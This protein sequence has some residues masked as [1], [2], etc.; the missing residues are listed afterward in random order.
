MTR[1]QPPETTAPLE[2][3]CPFCG[4]VVGNWK[5]HDQYHASTDQWAE[6]VNKSMRSIVNALRTLAG[7]PV[8]DDE[9]ADRA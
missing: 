2:D 5:L 8:D 9:E 3:V 1:K 4:A 7:L 6:R